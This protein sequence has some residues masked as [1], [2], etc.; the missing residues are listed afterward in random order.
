M[1]I[2]Q[3]ITACPEPPRIYQD[4]ATFNANADAFAGYI[5]I[6]G[7]QLNVF[8]GQLNVTAAAVIEAAGFVTATANLPAAGVPLTANKRYWLTAGASVTM[9]TAP[10]AGQWVEFVAGANLLSAPA[11][12]VFAHAVYDESGIALAAG[13]HSYNSNKIRRFIFNGS[14]WA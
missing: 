12:L 1:T 5:P 14:T 11:S 4:K 7:D 6:M 8:A 9:P 3:I 2:T 10:T 13:T